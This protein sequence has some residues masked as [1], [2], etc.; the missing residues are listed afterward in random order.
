MDNARFLYIFHGLFF[1]KLK[2]LLDD[3]CSVDTI[4]SQPHDVRGVF[5][6][7]IKLFK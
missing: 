1:V 3:L 4:L 7:G 6:K 5:E 2:L